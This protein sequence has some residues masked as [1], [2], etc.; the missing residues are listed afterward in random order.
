M[1]PQHPDYWLIGF[2]LLILVPCMILWGI[3]IYWYLRESDDQ[4]PPTRSLHVSGLGEITEE[5]LEGLLPQYDARH[6][7]NRKPKGVQKGSRVV[8]FPKSA[9][10]DLPRRNEGDVPS[11]PRG[12]AR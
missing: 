7:K 6:F 2:V 10:G 4:D 3:G 5:Q 1:L 12:H 11:L 9:Q 8:R